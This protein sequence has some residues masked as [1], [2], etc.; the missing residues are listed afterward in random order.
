MARLNTPK[1]TPGIILVFLLGFSGII[2]IIFFNQ[3]IWSG[4]LLS[5]VLWTSAIVGLVQKIQNDK[6]KDVDPKS[7][8][9]I[10]SI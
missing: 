2:L 1:S 4:V 9:K 8:I 6:S 10:D 7:K 5:G 3:P